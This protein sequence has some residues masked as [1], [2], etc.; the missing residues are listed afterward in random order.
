M[1]GGAFNC[2]PFF[3][4]FA[5]AT[6]CK[7]MPALCLEAWHVLNAVPKCALVARCSISFVRCSTFYMRSHIPFSA[8]SSRGD[9]QLLILRACFVPDCFGGG[10]SNCRFRGKKP[11]L[12]EARSTYA[13]F[14][15]SDL[16]S[17]FLGEDHP[18]RDDFFKVAKL[19]V[20][21]MDLADHPCSNPPTP[22]P[23]CRRRN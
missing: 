23:Q 15:S 20:I 13:K 7:Q 14:F 4:V 11:T 21:S 8:P 9:D 2:L 1:A 3:A 19:A 22:T 16:Q 17:T 12:N 18:T 6:Y 10:H 5:T